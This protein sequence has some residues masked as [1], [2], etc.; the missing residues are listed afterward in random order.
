MGTKRD[1][2]ARPY[3]PQC[4]I[5]FPCLFV[6]FCV[7]LWCGGYMLLNLDIVGA[8]YVLLCIPTQGMQY[9][10]E[11][12]GLATVALSYYALIQ[13]VPIGTRLF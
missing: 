12:D 5:L 10:L 1:I 11:C 7:E 13:N 2:T 8:W 6:L 4:P 9:V 3:V